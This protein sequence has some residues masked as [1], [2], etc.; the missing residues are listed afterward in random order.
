MR[1]DDAGLCTDLREYW[2]LLPEL[3]DPWPGW[4]E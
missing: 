3:R 4:G 2:Q 1:F